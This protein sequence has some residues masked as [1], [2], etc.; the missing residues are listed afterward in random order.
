[1]GSSTTSCGR[2]TAGPSP[3]RRRPAAPGSRSRSWR[4]GRSFGSWKAAR[5][6][7]DA[8]RAARGIALETERALEADMLVRRAILVA[9][10][11]LALAACGGAD[12]EGN[13]LGRAGG[14]G[15]GRNGT[16]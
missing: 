4:P 7:S 13:E 10:A 14:R 12:P 2:S 3:P 8:A 15:L 6:D 1:R 16:L 5:A 11:M 9:L